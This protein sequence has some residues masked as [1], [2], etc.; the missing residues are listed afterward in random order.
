MPRFITCLNC[1]DQEILVLCRMW[2]FFLLIFF[3][4]MGCSSYP[5]GEALPQK[6][7]YQSGDIQTWQNEFRQTL[8]AALELQDSPLT[9]PR[10]P[11]QIQYTIQPIDLAL[12]EYATLGTL[13]HPYTSL[14]EAKI[15]CQKKPETVFYFSLDPNQKPNG[16]L[17]LSDCDGLPSLATSAITLFDVRLMGFDGYALRAYLLWPAAQS[18]D[19]KLSTFV[20][21]HGHGSG[22]DVAALDFTSYHKAIGFRLAKNG[23]LTLVPDI[24]S[25]ENGNEAH[26]KFI[27]KSGEM[28]P[29][30]FAR[31][32]EDAYLW[33]EW[34][35]L[36]DLGV[37]R[38]LPQVA[39]TSL[40]SQIALWVG[41]LD[42]NYQAVTTVGG[43]YGFE[44]LF[45]NH[46]HSCQ[47]VPKLLGLANIMDVALLVW[48]RH[49]HIGMGGQDKFY[50]GFAKSAW[51][52]LLRSQ[53][54]TGASVC[55]GTP[56]SMP[57]QLATLPCQLSFELDQDA[58]HELTTQVS[59]FQIL[60]GQKP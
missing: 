22:R 32:L 3:V 45:S 16:G 37:Q 6:L 19:T 26:Y 59:T 54:Q 36:A 5:N 44:V 34:L 27:K 49:L 14:P 55:E 46:H 24:R 51:Q 57:S 48:P 58:G 10:K 25:F 53:R 7:S 50:N 2:R 21:W 8:L 17:K 43:F 60:A 33:G 30:I 28:H 38:A 31:W 42:A 41:A 4:L 1:Q 13:L 29:P 23:F 9:K 40:G 11:E 18:K 56:A 20:Y 47:H 52:S 15:I 39:G 35:R 12:P